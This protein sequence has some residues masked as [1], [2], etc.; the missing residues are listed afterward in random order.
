MWFVSWIFTDLVIDM[1]LATDTSSTRIGISKS[2][3]SKFSFP[4][5]GMFWFHEL[6]YRK[7]WKPVGFQKCHSSLF[8]LVRKRF[9]TPA[10][11]RCVSLT[12]K[13]IYICSPPLC[14]WDWA[15]M[16]K[17]TALQWKDTHRC[18]IFFLPRATKGIFPRMI[19]S[20]HWVLR[21]ESANRR[22]LWVIWL[23]DRQ[24]HL[25]LCIRRA[26]LHYRVRMLLS[27][28]F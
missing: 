24:N 25:L 8:W 28:F 6:T 2:R 1:F 18:V 13:N 12:T 11:K 26:A 15:Q 9:W 5:N 22:L 27:H 4:Q 20:K 7:S 16:W 14:L 17:I 3:N 19:L 23:P 10:R 21:I